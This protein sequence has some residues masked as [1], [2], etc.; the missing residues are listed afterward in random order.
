MTTTTHRLWHFLGSSQIVSTTATLGYN[1]HCLDMQHGLWDEAKVLA[2]IAS[3]PTEHFAVRLRNASYSNIGFAL[4]AG[5]REIIVPMINNAEQAAAVTFAGR[6]PP[7]GGR[8]WGP[9]TALSGSSV[10]DPQEANSKIRLAAMIET[11]Q[12]LANLDSII[13]TPGI[14]S[15]F[16][17]PFDLALDLG[18]S[19]D[20]LLSD[21]ESPLKRI[22]D[23]CRGRGLEVGAYA[24]SA[25]K[26]AAFEAMGYDW[27]VADSDT[28]L[29]ASGA[30]NA[31]QNHAQTVK[32][33]Y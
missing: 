20:A 30:R 13:D 1:W 8:S 28:A 24:G 31:L 19:V 32:T 26:A 21:P 29:L 22:A 11:R 6:Y 4:D 12:G 14:D 27:A 17:G 18:T 10:P 5:A 16:V 25:E 7:L 15:I 9:L 2:A 33:A 3:Q 23:A